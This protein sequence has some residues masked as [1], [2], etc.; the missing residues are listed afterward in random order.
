MWCSSWA[1]NDFLKLGKMVAWSVHPI[2]HQ[3]SAVYDITHGAGL[4]I[5]T[6]RWL[7]KMIQKGKYEKIAEWA[8]NVFDVNPQMDT[9]Q[10]AEQGIVCLEKYYK[11]LNLADHLSEFG[12]DQTHFREMAEKAAQQLNNSYVPLTVEEVIDIYKESL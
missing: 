9:V 12:I 6:P 5:L 10:K 4:A 7:R 3:L 11:K 8:E 2:E 1:I